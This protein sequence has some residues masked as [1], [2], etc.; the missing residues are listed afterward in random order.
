MNSLAPQDATRYWLSA[1]GCNDLF[2]LYCFDDAGASARELRAEVAARA[3]AIGDLRVRLR[4][5]RFAYPAWVRCEIAAEQIVEHEPP[6]STWSAVVA[7]LGGLLGDGLRA[8]VHAWRL[9]LFRGVS[10]A[11]GGEGPAVIAVLQLSHALADGQRSA[12]IARALWTNPG[13]SV[14]GA[15]ASAGWLGNF[16]AEASALVGMPLGVIRTIGRGF[17]A[18]RARRELDS[19]TARGEIPSPAPG[20]PPT[21]LNRPPVPVEHAVHMIVREDLRVP[22]RTVTV[23]VLTAISLA[24]SR[25]LAGRGEPMGLLGAQ[26]SMALPVDK[27]PVDNRVGDGSPGDSRVV[28]R[29]LVHRRPVDNR[30]P[31]VR[32]NYLD[33]GVELPV[34]EPDLVRRADRI[35]ADLAERRTRAR[36]PLLRAA[37]RVTEV[38]PAPVLRRDVAGYPSD[39]VPERIS[40]NTVVSS[41][42]RGPA[43][44][45]FGGGPVRFTAGFPAL[46]AVMHLTHGVHGLGATVT[47]SVHA[48]PAA[49]PDSDA[50]AVLVDNSLTEVVAALQP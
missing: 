13:G 14:G 40:G 12:A 38:I 26:V 19:L 24:L 39:L 46:G 2:L 37:D 9:H 20:F 15:V 42:D 35:A 25:Y 44:L 6:A 3:A 23:V 32:N 30:K 28:H 21:V 36:H 22:G 11:P 33:L 29:S 10:G 7:A 16:S 45:A 1:R 50:Y 34:D 31:M 49:M 17:A 27:S 48:D 5:R 18:A 43:D 8:E 41:V 4:E 47:V